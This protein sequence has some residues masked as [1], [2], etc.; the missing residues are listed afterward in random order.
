MHRVLCSTDSTEQ[1]FAILHVMVYDVAM[2]RGIHKRNVQHWGTKNNK[3]EDSRD[4]S[5][6]L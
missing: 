1:G 2:M 5:F 3:F 6:R 4:E